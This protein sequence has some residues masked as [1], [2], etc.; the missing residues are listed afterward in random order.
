MSINRLREFKCYRPD[1]PGDQLKAYAT[2][3]D[4]GKVR[5]RQPA[6]MGNSI[7]RE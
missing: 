1:M 4:C 5:I 2:C 3:E 7:Y 6:V